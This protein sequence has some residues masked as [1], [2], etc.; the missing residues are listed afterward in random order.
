M[1][2][3]KLKKYFYTVKYLK[4][5]QIMYQLYRSRIPISHPKKYNQK[6]ISL[7]HELFFLQTPSVNKSDNT[8]FIFNKPI[9]DLRASNILVDKNFDYL[10][11]FSFLY[12]DFIHKLDEKELNHFFCKDIALLE[13]KKNFYHPYVVSKRLINLILIIKNEKILNNN[14]KQDITYQINK[15][16]SYLYKNIE[17]NID[18][19]HL[20]TNF[21][22][23]SIYERFFNSNSVNKSYKKYLLEFSKQF[24]SGLHYERSM[25]YTSQLLHESFLVFQAHIN[26]TPADHIALIE[27]SLGL[28]NFYKK[29]GLK[30]DFV[31]NIFEQ[32]FQEKN[33]C[34]LYTRVFKKNLLEKGSSSPTENNNYVTIFNK[35]FA[36]CADCGFPSPSFQPGHAH[37]SSGAIELSFKSNPIFISGNVS[38]YENCHQRNIE[39]SR[40]NYSKIT[41]EGIFQ[42]VWSSFRVAKRVKPKKIFNKSEINFSIA[43]GAQGFSRKAII[44]DDQVFIIDNTLGSEPLVSQFILS[45]NC[46][47]LFNND[48][49]IIIDNNSSKLKITSTN[50]IAIEDL[51][52]PT[53]YGMIEYTKIIKIVSNNKLNILKIME[54]CS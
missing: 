41:S 51:E 16:A 37:D 38:T 28:I 2:F 4:I 7:V 6:D 43:S 53:G 21:A 15:D 13:C 23:L 35:K 40:F 29:I 48:S 46:R 26:E 18:G 19:N 14:L 20:L 31:D 11:F 17:F 5:R 9:Y 3:S 25:S 52:I 54:I 27:K 49:D 12:F 33:L 1:Y 45:T 22:A 42:D 24:K 50:S 36:V 8:I 30:V 47:V 10:Y 32:S 34:S 44:N 39:R